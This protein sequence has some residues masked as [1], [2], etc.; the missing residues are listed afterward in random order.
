M[1]LHFAYSGDGPKDKK[2][3]H[4]WM[5]GCHLLYMGSWTVLNTRLGRLCGVALRVK[6][7]EAGQK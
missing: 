7:A 3:K 4:V 5:R 1:H 6:K 2:E